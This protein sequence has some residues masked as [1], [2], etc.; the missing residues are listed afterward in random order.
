[1]TYARY[2]QENLGKTAPE[3]W[4]VDLIGR[5]PA[6]GRTELLTFKVSHK[7]GPEVT[8]ENVPFEEGSQTTHLQLWLA[9]R[10]DEVILQTD[11]DLSKAFEYQLLARLKQ[12]CEYYLGA[13]MLLLCRQL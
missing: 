3:D 7:G 11:V 10:E 2:P 5:V 13:G 9:N 1:M 6:A 4:T 12:D 8:L